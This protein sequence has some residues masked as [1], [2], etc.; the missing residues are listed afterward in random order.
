MRRILAGMMGLLL[1]CTLAVG[2]AAEHPVPDLTKNGSLT[3][4]MELDGKALDGGKLNLYKVGEITQ[5]DGN[6]GFCA[7]DQLQDIDVEPEATGEMKKEEIILQGAKK[8]NLPK[9]TT[10]IAGGEAVFTD[11]A[12]GLYLVWQEEADATKGYMPIKPFLI[13]VPNMQEGEYVSDI[14]A[15]PKVSLEKKPEKSTKPNPPTGDKLPQTGQLNWPIP[16]LVCSGLALL[17]MGGVL[18]MRKGNRTNGK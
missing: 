1:S 11:L 4:K 5:E 17:T 7:I 12:V 8:A 3:L 2:A 10:P 14:Q 13:S 15:A 9:I 16:V 6:Y 18:R